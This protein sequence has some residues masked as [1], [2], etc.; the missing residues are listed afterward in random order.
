MFV[1]IIKLKIMPSIA[2][3]LLFFHYPLS[4]ITNG[5]KV[6]G[7]ISIKTLSYRL[8][9]QY[10][11]SHAYSCVQWLEEVFANVVML[12]AS[13]ILD[14]YQ[15]IKC[16]NGKLHFQLLVCCGCGAINSSQTIQSFFLIA[17]QN[18]KIRLSEDIIHFRLGPGKIQKQLIW[19]L[20]L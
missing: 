16:R 13:G 6:T 14:C 7:G 3:L 18:L 20:P 15:N 19:N 5:T 8:V 11:H 12:L 17:S 9:Y 10:M 2:F 4:K 1:L